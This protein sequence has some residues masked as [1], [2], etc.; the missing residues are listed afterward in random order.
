MIGRTLPQIAVSATFCR[1]EDKSGGGN[2]STVDRVPLGVCE[3]ITPFNF[4]IMVP[5][6]MWPMA[7]AC[8]NTFVLKPSEKVPL[9]AVRELELAFEAGPAAGGAPPF[10][11]GP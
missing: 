6:W 10:A 9:S 3:G 1:T 8:G 4:P 11:R 7:V 5:L 2:D